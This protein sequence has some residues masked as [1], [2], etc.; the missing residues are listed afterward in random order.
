M[1]TNEPV[2]ANIVLS[3][4]LGTAWPDG[5]AVDDDDAERAARFLAERA[6]RTLGDGLDT[7]AVATRWARRW[8]SVRPA[9]GRRSRTV[10]ASAWC[11]AC[12]EELCGRC[13]GDCGEFLCD[14]CR[15]RRMSPF[16]DVPVTNGAL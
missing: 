6:H 12:G 11:E 16:E 13:W 5:V 9:C 8:R 7:V 14:V 4:T 1:D 2:A 10:A 3:A 15:C